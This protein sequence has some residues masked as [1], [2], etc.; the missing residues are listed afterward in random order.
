VAE[1]ARWHGSAAL[2]VAVT[3]CGRSS[4][5]PP[6]DPDPDLRC[7]GVESIASGEGSPG[8]IQVSGGALYWVN[9]GELL[10]AATDGGGRRIVATLVGV[11]AG[12]LALDGTRAYTADCDPRSGVCGV[13][14]IDIPTGTT[15]AVM[16]GVRVAT[17]PVLDGDRV[18]V[19]EDA[20]GGRVVSALVD[21]GA[22]LEIARAG[23]SAYVRQVAAAS[24]F[25]HWIVQTADVP[26]VTTLERAPEDGGA[27]ST[28]A[29]GLSSL[30]V[31]ANAAGAVY[32]VSPPPGAKVTNAPEVVYR[33]AADGTLSTVVA[34]WP[35]LVEA[36]DLAATRDTLVVASR[37]DTR[38]LI[39]LLPQGAS[40]PAAVDCGT[41]LNFSGVA[42]DDQYVY[43]T[44]A[45]GDG[46]VFRKHR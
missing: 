2:A 27:V 30:P 15:D 13:V 38:T 23:A 41:S 37:R 6:P 9:G 32:L 5:P 14:R 31:L 40:E 19:G 39:E 10:S 4:A 24:G 22:P 28:V 35:S 46:R 20:M 42:L 7:A 12:G 36:V 1:R 25:V 17:R 34:S 11:A 45:A 3:A 21:G 44:E 29:S 18:F 16:T 43:W 26:P 33:V 8:A